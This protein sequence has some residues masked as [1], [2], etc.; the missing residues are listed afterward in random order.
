M[1]GERQA[2]TLTR[3]RAKTAWLFLAPTLIALVMVGLWPLTRTLWLSLTDARLGDAAAASFIGFANYRL[4]LGD[5]EW[6][7]AVW[8]TLI[9][10]AS[11][12]AIET[13]LGIVFA[14]VMNAR[15]RGRGL[16]RAAIL[17]P[18]AIPLVVSGK[19][20]AWMYNDLYGVINAALLGLG[21]IA[22][23]IAWLAAADLAMAA[24][25]ATDV[26]KTTPFMALLILAAL[27]MVPK[28]VYEAARLD[29]V[30]P[31]VVF[32]RITL[33]LIRPVLLVAVIFRTLDALRIFD[34]IYIMTS[35]S[36][37]TAT[38]SIFARRE[39]VEFADVG[40]GS[41]ASVLIFLIVGLCTLAYLWLARLRPEEASP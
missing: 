25:V 15:F 4:L 1:S 35:N 13:V 27:Q 24:V 36:R 30:S 37:Q 5:A 22:E 2:S 7:N 19:M 17:V 33:P 40:Y 10:A 31:V 14:L 26:W 9:F 11:S 41:A 3:R 6:W 20:W 16:V 34:L 38:M 23:P 8:N 39:L 32:F 18:W 21:V 12:V 28:D 29:G